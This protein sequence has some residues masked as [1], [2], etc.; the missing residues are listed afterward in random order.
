MV[1]IS[2]TEDVGKE[3]FFFKKKKKK[4]TFR[5][6]RDERACVDRVVIVK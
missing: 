5:A 2:I 1:R 3:E 4:L 6:R